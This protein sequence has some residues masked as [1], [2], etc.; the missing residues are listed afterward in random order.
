MILLLFQ[1]VSLNHFNWYQFDSIFVYTHILFSY[2]CMYQFQLVYSFF[3]H[4]YELF[5]L[6]LKLFYMFKAQSCL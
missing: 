3:I 4:I 1:L 5:V 2:I 6:E